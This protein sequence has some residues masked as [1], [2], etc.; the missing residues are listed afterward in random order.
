MGLSCLIEL[1]MILG[2]RFCFR[3]RPRGF[4]NMGASREG[5]QIE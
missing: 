3:G 5:A 1:F 4:F 2:I